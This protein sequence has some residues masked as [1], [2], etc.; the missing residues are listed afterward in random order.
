MRY[1]AFA[2]LKLPKVDENNV[3]DGDPHFSNHRASD[4]SKSWLSVEAFDGQMQ[5]PQV[6]SNF[7][8]FLSI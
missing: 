6:S 2:V 1:V 4:C 8:V 3:A 5:T 7:A